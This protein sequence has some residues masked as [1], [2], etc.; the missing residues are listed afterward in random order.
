MAYKSITAHNF[1]DAQPIKDADVF[2]VRA[3]LH[4]WSD[5]YC[6]QILR[7]LR[8]A[9]TPST[10][11]VVVDNLMSYA[12][13]DDSLKDVPGSEVD[14]PPAPLLPNWGH[15]R[16]VWYYEDLGMLNLMNG[17]ERTMRDI[18]DLLESSGWKLVRL[19]QDA[20]YTTSKAIAVPL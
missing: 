17:K 15:A 13:I 1:F 3:I 7:Q 19:V 9:A 4:N 14:L 10:Q 8:E 6:H 2:L 5:K 16:A 12:C 20:A 18:R 11:L